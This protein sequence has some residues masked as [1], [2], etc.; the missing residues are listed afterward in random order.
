MSLPQSKEL[1]TQLKGFR[2]KMEQ[3]QKELVNMKNQIN[4]KEI[5]MRENQAKLMQMLKEIQ[6]SLGPM[7]PKKDILF[8]GD[9]HSALSP[10]EKRIAN[11]QRSAE[12]RKQD[13]NRSGSR[14]RGPSAQMANSGSN[15]Y[16]NHMNPQI[17]PSQQN[18][19]HQ[20]PADVEE[21]ANFKN[22]KN[23][24]RN[25]EYLLEELDANQNTKLQSQQELDQNI[26][27][28]LSDSVLFLRNMEDLTQNMGRGHGTMN[29]DHY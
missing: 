25:L 27:N 18:Y 11:Y 5:N 24:L 6:G 26:Q 14:G 15:F 21:Q 1:G 19:M 9:K 28:V 10:F 4:F 29:K 13:Y 2:R 22:L 17:L 7:E 23:K 20:H 8:S 3:T 16:P 12:M